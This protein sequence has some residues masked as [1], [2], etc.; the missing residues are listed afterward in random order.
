MA[1]WYLMPHNYHL[2]LHFWWVG[3][4]TTPPSPKDFSKQPPAPPAQ[5]MSPLLSVWVVTRVMACASPA[6]GP[7][8]STPQSVRVVSPIPGWL[9]IAEIEGSWSVDASAGCL[10]VSKERKRAQFC[11]GDG[12]ASSHAGELYAGASSHAGGL[13]G[14]QQFAHLSPFSLLDYHLKLPE[15]WM[16]TW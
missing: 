14:F 3:W 1:G 12:D 2:A 8:S 5:V 4:L 15:N 11:R 16:M 9:Q 13:W 7:P 6:T 10:S